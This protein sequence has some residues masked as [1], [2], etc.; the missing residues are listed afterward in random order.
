M[1]IS[2]DDNDYTTGTS[3]NQEKMEASVKEYFTSKWYQRAIKELV[4]TWL[5]PRLP[6]LDYYFISVPGSLPVHVTLKQPRGGGSFRESIPH[7]DIQEVKSFWDQRIVRKVA[8]DG[9]TR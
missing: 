4:E 1:S 9:G 2:Y 5:H 3:N 8:S 7:L 6:H